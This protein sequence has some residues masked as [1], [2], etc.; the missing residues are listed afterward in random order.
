MSATEIT[1]DKI[2]KELENKVLQQSFEINLKKVVKIDK[3]HYAKE[4]DRESILEIIND[5]K[6]RNFIKNELKAVQILTIG[7]PEIVLILCLEAIRNNASMLIVI[8]DFCLAQNTFIVEIMNQILKKYK[9]EILIT[10]ENLPTKNK[11]IE[12]SKKYDKTI[13]VG[14]FNRYNELINEVENIKFYPY[15]MLEL[16][17][18]SEEFEELKRKLYDYASLNGFVLEIYDRELKFDDVINLMNK[19]SYGFA[20]ILFSKDEQ[21]CNR[22]KSEV[23][24]QYVIINENPFKKI[25]FKLEL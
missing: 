22:F 9:S 20:S 7:N 2:L 25:R 19:D 6:S 16:Y 5:Y 10:L 11:L 17:S 12:N 3:N 18:D 14:D 8:D 13:S 24:S 15:G 4:L 1:Y 23:K 21:K